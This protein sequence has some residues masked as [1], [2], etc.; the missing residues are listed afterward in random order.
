MLFLVQNATTM[1]T[2]NITLDNVWAEL[3]DFQIRSY[4]YLP[5]ALY[6]G[7]KT[8]HGQKI[9][10]EFEK[11]YNA[12]KNTDSSELVETMIQM[13]KDYRENP[14]SYDNEQGK[15]LQRIQTQS[16]IPTGN[17]IADLINGVE[18][19]PDSSGNQFDKWN[20][21]IQNINARNNNG[22]DL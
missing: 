3:T 8:R 20:Q 21:A 1:N 4:K 9:A 2:E 7:I 6:A 18:N 16:K 15:A 11:E 14:E 13:N 17:P 22:K 12:L 10:D 5:S 19:Q